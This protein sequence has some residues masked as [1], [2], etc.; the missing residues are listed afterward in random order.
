MSVI[1]CKAIVTCY[2]LILIEIFVDI[3]NSMKSQHQFVSANTVRCII[4]QLLLY[5]TLTWFFDVICHAK[6]QVQ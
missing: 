4:G 5:S 1:H 2:Q 3:S 6:L